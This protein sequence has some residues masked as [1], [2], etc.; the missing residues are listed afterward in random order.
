MKISGIQNTVNF[1]GLMIFENARKLTE[2]NE[3]NPLLNKYETKKEIA[4]STDGIE[5]EPMD[6]E[7]YTPEE[8]SNSQDILIEGSKTILSAYSALYPVKIKTAQGDEYE[9]TES[10]P[11]VL[12]AYKQVAYR[13]KVIDVATLEQI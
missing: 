2:K 11:I 10:F 1:K 9:V 12:E 3:E 7:L 6:K 5:I 8:K 13:P 4:L